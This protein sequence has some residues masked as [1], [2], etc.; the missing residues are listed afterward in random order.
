MEAVVLALVVL[1]PWAFGGVEPGT[2]FVLAAG[3]VIL[4]A[5]WTAITIVT[6]RFRLMACPIA[7]CLGGI[8]ILGFLQLLPIPPALQHGLSLGSADLRQELLPAQP[9][10]LTPT[11]AVP[12]APALWPPSVYPYVTRVETV[13]WLAMFALF[14]VVRSQ[15]AGAASLRRLCVAVTL[16]G[17]LLA[18]FGL[19]HRL[20]ARP[21][22][23]F[24]TIETPGEVFGPFVYH[25]HYAAYTNLCLGLGLGLL[26]ATVWRR[27]CPSPSAGE[28]SSL[29]LGL[30][31]R[32]PDFSPAQLWLC[33]ALAL[34]IGG[35]VC[36]LSRGGVAAL[37][38]GSAI[39]LLIRYCL[40]SGALGDWT[41]SCSRQFFWRSC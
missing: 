19:A 17:A 20:S 29:A 34:M 30:G 39:V 27:F 16:N 40:R 25:N 10:L 9:E 14:V 4:L 15:V 31:Q 2:Q 22:R 24:W 6:G 36:S 35:L 12:P 3:I 32:L 13:R 1:S 38:I 23:I 21:G 7:L 18:L 28:E 11:E 26:L 33:L 8:T 37:A 5:L 41:D